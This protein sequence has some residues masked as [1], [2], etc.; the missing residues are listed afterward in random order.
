MNNL[1]DDKRMLVYGPKSPH[2]DIFCFSTTRHGGCSEGNY[3]SFNCNHYCGDVPDKVE[4]NR[5]LLCS[6]LPVR[7][8]MLVVPLQTHDTVVRVVDEVFLRLSSE[9]QMKQLEGV[10]AMVRDMAQVSLCISTSD[11]RP[12]L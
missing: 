5:E 7:P 6:L 3:A 2:T 4:R 8:R 12:V 9:E 1:T 10:D 11:C